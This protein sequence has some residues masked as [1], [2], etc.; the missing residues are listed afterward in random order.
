MTISNF[1]TTNNAK[2]VRLVTGNDW[3]RTGTGVAS[4]DGGAGNDT[5]I[6]GALNDLVIGGDGNDTVIDSGADNSTSHENIWY[7]DNGNNF[8]LGAGNDSLTVNGNGNNTV[9]AGDR[10]RYGLVIYGR[11]Q[12]QRCSRCRQ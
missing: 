10:Q 6:T 5:I 7:W 12:R 11:W 1:G 3:V 2:Q 4:V 8:D 9:S